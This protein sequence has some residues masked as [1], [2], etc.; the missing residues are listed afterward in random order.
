MEKQK[1]YPSFNPQKALVWR[2]VHCDNLP[3]IL[4]N[5]LHCGNSTVKAPNWVNIGNP[6]LIDKRANHPV[7]LPPG[8]VLNDYVPF[9]FTPFSPMLLNIITG[10]GGIQKQPRDAIVF[11]VSSL[12][13]IAELGLPFLFT[14]CHAYYEWANF[15]ADLSNLDKVDWSLLQARDFKR[16]PEDPEKF[17]RYQAEALVYQHLPVHG[18]LGIVCHDEG[19]KRHIAQELQARSLNL[20][21]HVRKDWYF[22]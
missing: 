21:V 14:D 8:G 2:I 16:D 17:E 18:L 12:H 3:W 19:Q 5:G 7:P 20:P 6:E 4:G 9:Y 11:L 1:H 10:R 22:P 15:Y 13:R